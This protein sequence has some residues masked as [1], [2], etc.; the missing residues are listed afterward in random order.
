MDKI[1]DLVGGMP[2]NLPLFWEV[3]HEINLIDPGKRII[4]C[5]PKCPD[6]LKTELAKKIS[7][8]TSTGW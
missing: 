3:N 8:Y 4:Y 7:R 2:P 6:V 5:L 1:A